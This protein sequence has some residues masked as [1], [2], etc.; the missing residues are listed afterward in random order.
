[1][2]NAT[3]QHTGRQNQ[4]DTQSGE[5]KHSNLLADDAL[6]NNGVTS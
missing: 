5:L 6:I 1:M 2:N 3:C 4:H